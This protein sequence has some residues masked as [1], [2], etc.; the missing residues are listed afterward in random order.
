M[1]PGAA[2]AARVRRAAGAGA[3][4]AGARPAGEAVAAAAAAAARV[5]GGLRGVDRRRVEREHAAGPTAATAG[6]GRAGGAAIA[7][8]LDAALD[9]ELHARDQQQR[10]A[11]EAAHVA[12][13]VAPGPGEPGS[14][15][16]ISAPCD[17]I[18]SLCVATI[19][20]AFEPVA[21]TTP[22][23]SMSLLVTKQTP[24]PAWTGT[25]E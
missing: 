10:A 2:Q 9:H 8:D 24:S 13:A 18:W 1:I 15:P 7:A 17:S 4:A 14:L 5:E 25:S 23:M 16:A 21:V 12:T 6:V 11:A 20:S 19:A 22:A 3:I